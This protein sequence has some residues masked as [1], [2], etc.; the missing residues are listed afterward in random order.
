MGYRV[1]SILVRSAVLRTHRY[2]VG[3]RLGEG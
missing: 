2:P 3:A 1:P